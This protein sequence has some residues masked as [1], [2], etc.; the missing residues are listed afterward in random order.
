MSIL[1]YS[2]YTRINHS[3]RPEAEIFLQLAARGH[4]VCIF[5]PKLD[6]EELFSA[7]GIRTETTGQSAKISISSIRALRRELHLPPL[8]RELR[9]KKATRGCRHQ[10]REDMRCCHFV[11]SGIRERSVV[12]RSQHKAAW[13]RSLA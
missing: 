2:D 9:R 11:K 3:V 10:C 7:A 8:R 13:F 6:P 5:S 4:R 1:V 12:F